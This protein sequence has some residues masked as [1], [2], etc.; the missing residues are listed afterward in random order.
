S[1]AS[2][3]QPMVAY[4]TSAGSGDARTDGDTFV[5]VGDVEASLGVR[6]ATGIPIF[7]V[8][9]I[10]LERGQWYVRSGP[11]GF[12]HRGEFAEPLPWWT[13]ALFLDED[14]TRLAGLGIALQFE[15]PPPEEPAPASAGAGQ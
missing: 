11:R 7:L 12:E 14:L 10:P 15:P 5:V 9:P 13:R 6:T 3:G 8:P 4:A 1:C 2:T